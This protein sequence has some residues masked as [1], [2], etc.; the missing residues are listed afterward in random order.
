M[1]PKKLLEQLE[2]EATNE[3]GKARYEGALAIYTIYNEKARHYRE[4]HREYNKIYQR[5]Y[6]RKWRKL[7][8]EQA[9]LEQAIAEE[10]EGIK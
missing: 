3:I 7:K 4:T 6:H 5:E 8:K 10:V 1:T 9:E 2:T